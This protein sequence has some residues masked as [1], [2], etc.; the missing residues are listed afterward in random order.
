MTRFIQ[1]VWIAGVVLL[2]GGFASANEQARLLPLERVAAGMVFFPYPAIVST[3]GVHLIRSVH[4]RFYY[5]SAVKPAGAAV[6]SGTGLNLR[7]DPDQANRQY[8]HVPSSYS[9]QGPEK[10]QNDLASEDD[11]WHFQA[12][13]Q[14][15]VNHEHEKG[16]TFSVR[17]GF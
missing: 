3:A 2:V 1:K 9:S 6:L 4:A 12:N 17:R 13:P 16:M 14:L 11:E 5:G 7:L 15:G 8:S 10:S